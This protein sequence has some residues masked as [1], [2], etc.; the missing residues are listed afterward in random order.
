MAMNSNS[1]GSNNV[2]P[3]DDRTHPYYLHHSDS[4]GLVLVSQV[5]TG[6]NHN[7]WSQAMNIALSVKNKIGFINGALPMPNSSNISN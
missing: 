7:S 2:A 3:I 5:L 4:P 1:S 6:E